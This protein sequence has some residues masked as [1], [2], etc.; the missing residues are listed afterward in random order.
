MWRICRT[1]VS[2]ARHERGKSGNPKNVR[3]KLCHGIVFGAPLCPARPATLQKHLYPPPF[4]RDARL[5]HPKLDRYD[6]E[7]RFAS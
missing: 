4:N 3:G 5:S 6:V 7:R 1:A 2:R